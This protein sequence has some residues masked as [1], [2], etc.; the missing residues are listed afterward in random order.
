MVGTEVC[1]CVVVLEVVIVVIG[2]K[3]EVYRSGA[4]AMLNFSGARAKRGAA[5]A[6]FP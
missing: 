3:W 6:V 1:A 5:V 2:F 4:R